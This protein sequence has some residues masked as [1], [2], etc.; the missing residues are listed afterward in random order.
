MV[1][2]VG[3]A[4]ASSL[5]LTNSTASSS[6][7]DSVGAE[8]G[9]GGDEPGGG[10]GGGGHPPGTGTLIYYQVRIPSLLLVLHWQCGSR[11][12][13]VKENGQGNWQFPMPNNRMA[14]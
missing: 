2:H 4:V 6:A 12:A 1:S 3:S 7:G 5:N 8:S 14:K 9:G 10:G 11:D 13:L